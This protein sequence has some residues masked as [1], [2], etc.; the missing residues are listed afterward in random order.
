MGILVVQDHE[1]EEAIRVIGNDFL[2]VQVYSKSEIDELNP[3]LIPTILE[4]ISRGRKELRINRQLILSACSKITW[5]IISCG[6]PYKGARII[7][8]IRSLHPKRNY[9]ILSGKHL[10]LEES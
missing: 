10:T 4:D 7:S 1:K 3:G 2:G 5:Q 6:H 8:N 9:S